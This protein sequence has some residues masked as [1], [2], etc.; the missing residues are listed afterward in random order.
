MQQ[1]E[2]TRTQLTIKPTKHMKHYGSTVL[3]DLIGGSADVL[4]EV[5]PGDRLDGELAAV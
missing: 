2:L 5:G 4:P 1:D 3:S